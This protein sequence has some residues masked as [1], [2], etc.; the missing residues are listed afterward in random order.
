MGL[1]IAYRAAEIVF[2]PS[3]LFLRRSRIGHPDFRGFQVQVEL[4]LDI[5]DQLEGAYHI[6]VDQGAAQLRWQGDGVQVQSGAV[7]SGGQGDFAVEI[8]QSLIFHAELEALKRSLAGHQ[9]HGELAI[10]GKAEAAAHFEAQHG[11]IHLG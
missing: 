5:I 8:G 4:G 9:Q 10:A 6:P 7:F 11:V 3:H 2:E 1:V